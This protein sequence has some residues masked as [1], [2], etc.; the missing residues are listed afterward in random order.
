MVTYRDAGIT[1]SCHLTDLMKH[2]TELSKGL[3][4]SKTEPGLQILELGTGCG[5]VGISLAQLFLDAKVVLT[6]LPEAEEIVQRNIDA[7][8][9][10]PE[11]TLSFKNLDWDA[12]LPP[13][14]QSWSSRLNLVIAADCTYNPDSR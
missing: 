3:P 10:L 5:M 11:D 1:L 4:S 9:G 2:N 12:E 8:L 6:D 7:A 14:I 13:D